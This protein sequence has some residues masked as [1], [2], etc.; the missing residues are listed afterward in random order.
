[1]AVACHFARFEF[2]FCAAVRALGVAFSGHI[3]V[4]LGVRVPDLHVG[5]GAWAKDATLWVQV[6]GEKFNSLA[7]VLF[8]SE[9]Q[10]R[11]NQCA[12]LGFLPFTMSKNA[13]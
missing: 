6:F 13:V 10:T 12:Y 9:N 1:M 3:Q 7:H 11:V 5:F 8:L 2:V 4:N